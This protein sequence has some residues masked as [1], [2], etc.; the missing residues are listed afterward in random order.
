M[1]PR[2]EPTL[3][4]IDN[5]DIV[6]YSLYL[7]GGAGGFVDVEELFLRCH[8][9]APERFSWRTRS[10]P[11]YKTLSKALRD[12]E[13]KHPEAMIKTQSGLGRQLSVEGL[14]W[15]ERNLPRLRAAFASPVP[16]AARVKSQRM[17]RDLAARPVVI[18]FLQDGTIEPT[19]YE[20]ADALICAPDS[21]ASVWLERLR[22]YRSAV[23]AARRTDLLSFLDFVESQRPDWF[24][25]AP[26]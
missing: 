12:Y 4:P 23:A 11:N 25:G 15:V 5:P 16:A 24:G 8:E 6:P 18:R 2:T 22:T 7:L 17:V 19:K 3:S 26:R 9:L 21:P 20:M 1:A 14:R 10:L 13:A